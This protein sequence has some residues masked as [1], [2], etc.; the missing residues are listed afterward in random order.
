MGGGDNPVEQDP[1]RD[2]NSLLRYQMQLG[3]LTGQ[4]ISPSPDLMGSIL[5]QQM[6]GNYS[7]RKGIIRFDDGSSIKLDPLTGKWG[8]GSS[9]GG[10]ST[11]GRYDKYTG[12][13]IPGTSSP[14]ITS[15]KMQQYIDMA[16]QSTQDIRSSVFDDP[17]SAYNSLTK[18]NS[19]VYD[20]TTGQY[21]TKGSINPEVMDSNYYLSKYG[22]YLDDANAATPYDYQSLEPVND[23]VRANIYQSGA[24]KIATHLRDTQQATQDFVSRQGSNL[25]SGRAARLQAQDKEEADRART[26]LDRETKGE[27]ELRRYEDANRLRELKGN[28]ARWAYETNQRRGK[29]KLG[30]AEGI[31]TQLRNQGYRE[32]MGDRQSRM[33]QLDRWLQ[34][35]GYNIQQNSNYA[36]YEAQKNAAGASALSGLLGAAGTAVG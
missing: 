18:F 32:M 17:N 23:S 34:A 10:Q 29:E 2:E 27:A 8:P 24:D 7:T 3:M 31:D 19:Q 26:A 6:G 21:V 25:S 13:W 35:M 30:I 33:D 16:N 12:K 1:T 4:P 9:G 5:A 11:T 36:Q 28:E 22:G 14:G 15:D 20:P